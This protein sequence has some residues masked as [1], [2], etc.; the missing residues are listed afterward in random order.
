MKG[1]SCSFVGVCAAT[2]AAAS[3][4]VTVTKRR[5]VASLNQYRER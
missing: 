5:I 3:I 1:F 2:A 4:A